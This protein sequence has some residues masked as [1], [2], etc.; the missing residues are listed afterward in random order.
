MKNESGG[1][2][3][4]TGE[5]KLMVWGWVALALAVAIGMAV[6]MLSAAL[7]T[8]MMILSG[9]GGGGI[10]ILC[11]GKAVA[12]VLD[13]RGRREYLLL[14]GNAEVLAARKGTPPVYVDYRLLQGKKDN[15]SHN[16][17]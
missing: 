8:S 12:V 17:Q 1:V 9:A 6:V 15:G 4:E 5:G 3:V 10:V 14:H 7:S 16:R 13:A 11:L 2:T